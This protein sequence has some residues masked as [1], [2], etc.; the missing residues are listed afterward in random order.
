MF[1]HINISQDNNQLASSSSGVNCFL[2]ISTG[3]V[4]SFLSPVRKRII[5]FSIITSV[6]LFVLI[7][8]SNPVDKDL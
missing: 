5:S 8:F 2:S 6:I 4:R 1:N 3:H 7:S